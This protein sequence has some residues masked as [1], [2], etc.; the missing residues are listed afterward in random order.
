MDAPGVAG[1]SESVKMDKEAIL[2]ELHQ[3][4]HDLE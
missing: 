2:E 4:K 3:L 1:E